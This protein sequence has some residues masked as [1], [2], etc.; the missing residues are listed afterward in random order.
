[1]VASDSI[2]VASSV[3]LL[4]HPNFSGP[5]SVLYSVGKLQGTAMNNR[6]MI[7]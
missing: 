6:E 4:Y 1:M 7:S 5:A 3:I 2:I